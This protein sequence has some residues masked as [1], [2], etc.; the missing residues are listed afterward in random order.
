MDYTTCS[1]ILPL[2]GKSLWDPGS[3]GIPQKH[4]SFLQDQQLEQ[5]ARSEQNAWRQVGVDETVKRKKNLQR[6]SQVMF[7]AW[8]KC[9]QLEV[10]YITSI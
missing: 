8:E 3:L 2:Q 9:S 6:N 4:V 5:L 10:R 7:G 1:S